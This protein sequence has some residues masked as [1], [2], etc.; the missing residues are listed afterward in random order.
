MNDK[1]IGLYFGID[2]D[3]FEYLLQY[4]AKEGYHYHVPHCECHGENT[5]L[6][7]DY[8]HFHLDVKQ[9]RELSQECIWA[10]TLQVYPLECPTDRFDTYEG[11]LQSSC[12]YCV[13]M[14]DCGWVEIY[15]KSVEELFKLETFLS[16]I[17]T[18]NLHYVS[19]PPES[20]IR[21]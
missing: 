13:I 3:D 18:E 12:I 1:I 20:F 11:F 15:A 19:T 9:L 17:N 2:N 7:G 21:D 10:M 8:Y 14:Y 16:K 6:P 4:F 5:I